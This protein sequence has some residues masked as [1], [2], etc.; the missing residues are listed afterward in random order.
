[1]FSILNLGLVALLASHSDAF[2]RM[3][4]PGRLV[5]ERADPLIFPGQIGAHVHHIAG[6]NG[7][8]LTTSYDNLRES[9]CSSCPITQDLSAY[10]TPKLYFQAQNGSFLSV[11]VAGDGQGVG[12]GMTVYYL[13]VP[14][15]ETQVFLTNVNLQATPGKPT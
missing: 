11:P 7:F 8:G 1:M 5:Q 3:S 15:S 13:Y 9:S 14:L 2:W 10:W 12:G 4:C 6:G